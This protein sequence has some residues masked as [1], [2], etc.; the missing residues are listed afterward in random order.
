MFA[1]RV[2]IGGGWQGYRHIAGIGDGNRDR[3]PDLYA[4]TPEG[5]PYY[6]Q[7]TGTAPP[8][9]AHG[10]TSPSPSAPTVPHPTSPD[11]A[12]P[13]Q[14]RPARPEERAAPRRLVAAQG[15]GIAPV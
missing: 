8:P 13:Q 10:T 12:E 3:R 14:R 2:K 1:T 5:I 15:A 9:S 6:Y 11:A 4:T 7:G